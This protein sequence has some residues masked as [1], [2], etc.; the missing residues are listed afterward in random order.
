MVALYNSTNGPEW[1]NNSN[2][3]TGPVSSWYGIT[4]S[5]MR[6]TEINLEDNNLIGTIPPEIRNLSNLHQL[7]FR[8][9]QLSGEIPVEIGYLTNLSCLDFFLNNLSGTIPHEIGNL[10]NI[11]NLFLMGNNLSG[12]IPDEI[13]NLINLEGYFGLSGNKLS[14]TIPASFGNF[15]KLQRLWISDNNLEGKVPD[16]FINLEELEELDLFNNQLTDL[17]DL[18]ALDSLDWLRIENNQFTFEDIEP[19]IGFPDSSFTYSPQ[20]SIGEI[21]DTIFYIDS[22]YILLVSAGGTSNRYQWKKNGEN[23]GNISTDSTYLIN[24]VTFADSGTY[25]CEITNTL[26]TELTLYSK[27]INIAVD[28]SPFYKDSMALVALYNSTDGPNWTNNTNWLT[29]SVSKWYGITVINGRVA[30]IN[31]FENNLSGTIPIEIANLTA[32]KRIKVWS[33]QLTGT[34]PS[35]IGNL[36]EL[37]SLQLNN[38]NFSGTIPE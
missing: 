24:N 14:G 37:E 7:S 16:S 4:V 2:W 21:I 6:V 38:N 19:H 1:N 10:T 32:L 36:T 8:A 34:I 30:K 12:S 27:P 25:T 3:L 33:N 23:I 26:A 29:D 11:D 15:I 18:S 9:N 28:Y 17:P 5:E 22:S 35:E 20:D 31:L 13:G